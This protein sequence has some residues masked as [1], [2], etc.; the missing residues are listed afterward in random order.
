[1]SRPTNGEAALLAKNL[2]VNCGFAVFPCRADKSPACPHGFRDASHDPAAILQLWHR[3]PGELIGIAT[4]VVSQIWVVDIDVKHPESC[5]WWHGNHQRLLPTRTYATRSGGV[6]LH[7]RDGHG[8]GCT[9]GRICKGVD[10][11]GDGGYAI[12][13]FAAGLACH[14]QSPPAHWPV[15]LRDA[16]AL[17][18]RSVGTASYRTHAEL[19][20]AAVTGIVRCVAQ[21]RVGERNAVLFWATCR[22]AERGISHLE[23]EAMLLPIAIGIGLSDLEARRTIASAQRRPGRTAA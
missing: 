6:H 12:Y 22:L 14:D 8:I 1:M 9:T 2:A 10:T 21:A 7:F 23:A 13:W 18:S 3:W 19:E 5:N 11:R 16:L 20:S 17:P 4:G 15:W